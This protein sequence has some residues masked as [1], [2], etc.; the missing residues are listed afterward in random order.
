VGVHGRGWW[1]FV[2]PG[3]G[4][5]DWPELFAALAK[6]GYRGDMAV[7][8]EDNQYMD[9]RWNEGLT[10]GLKTLRPLVDAYRA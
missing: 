7:E 6:A 3:L 5:I 4:Q 8:H 9:R 2:I 1:R 10:I